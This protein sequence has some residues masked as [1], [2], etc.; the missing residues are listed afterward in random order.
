MKHALIYLFFICAV[1]ILTVK[2]DF[3]KSVEKSLDI[4]V[5]ASENNNDPII[6]NRV[7]PVSVL[8]RTHI[9][10]I[11]CPEPLVPL[12]DRIVDPIPGDSQR[13]PRTIHFAW[14]RGY[15]SE[16]GRCLSQDMVSC[17][18]LSISFPR[19]HIFLH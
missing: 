8:T 5:S 10:D 1:L 2:L 14:I 9:R 4:Q 3:T 15:H 19:F 7:P 13:I 6:L 12:Y 11:K 17:S 16:T 18:H